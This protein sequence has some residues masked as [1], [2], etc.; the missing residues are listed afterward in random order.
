MYQARV[1][2]L[3]CAIL[4]LVPAIF[5]A[6]QHEPQAEPVESLPPGMTIRMIITADGQEY[7]VDIPGVSAETQEKPQQ[8]VQSPVMEVFPAMPDPQNGRVYRVQ[9]GAFRSELLARR[10]YDRLRD[11]GFSPAIEE[12]GPPHRVVISGV[13]SADVPQITL[14]L[15][16]AGFSEVWIREEN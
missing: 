6:A 10:C 11:A 15:S 14:K 5:C 12:N 8:T 9:V 2:L 4:F 3:F 1:F 7:T 16:L 13:P